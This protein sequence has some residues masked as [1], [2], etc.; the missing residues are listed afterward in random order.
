MSI[1][2]FCS[3]FSLNTSEK[4][5][6]ESTRRT[7]VISLMSA[8]SVT[9]TC[10][11]ASSPQR[12]QI[13]LH[14]SLEKEKDADGMGVSNPAEIYPRPHVDPSARWEVA[15]AVGT[16]MRYAARSTLG[17]CPRCAAGVEDDRHVGGGTSMIDC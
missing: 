10:M 7:G 11:L 12:I 5:P 1:P 2:C 13:R 3:T 9:A 16:W 14:K 17:G 4:N 15:E 8:I 6:R